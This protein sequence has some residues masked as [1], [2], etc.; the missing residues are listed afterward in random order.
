M[1][2]IVL[3]LMLLMSS[4]IQSALQNKAQEGLFY[5]QISNETLPELPTLEELPEFPVLIPSLLLEHLAAG[6]DRRVS[7][8]CR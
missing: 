4:Y 1:K 8:A 6:R 5:Q 3:F 2:C 7:P